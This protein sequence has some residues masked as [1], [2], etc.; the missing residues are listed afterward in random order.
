[1]RQSGK[2]RG[3]IGNS[4]NV[5]ESH[6]LLVAILGHITSTALTE[7]H[8]GPPKPCHSGLAGPLGLTVFA[9]VGSSSLLNHSIEH[10]AANTY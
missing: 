9:P 6:R 3:F 2:R 1:M 4:Q 5:G 10:T 8:F 7:E